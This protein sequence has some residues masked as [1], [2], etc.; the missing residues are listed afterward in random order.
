MLLQ[1]P[2]QCLQTACS[3]CA[4][5]TGVSSAEPKG[6]G[7]KS[8]DAAAGSGDIPVSDNHSTVSAWHARTAVTLGPPNTK[9]LSQFL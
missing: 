5:E 8:M 9:V 4:D 1:Y 3:V 6:N 7:P 2:R